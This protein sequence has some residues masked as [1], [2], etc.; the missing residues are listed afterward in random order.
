MEWRMNLNLTYDNMKTK[1]ILQLI[2]FNKECFEITKDNE[3][4]N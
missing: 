4:N 2:K 1:E 3:Y